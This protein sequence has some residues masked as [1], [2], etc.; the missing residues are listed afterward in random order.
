MAGAQ[1]L[2]L[3]IPVVPDEL[4]RAPVMLDIAREAKVGHV[5]Y[6]SMKQAD[7]FADVAHAASK[8]A[9]EAAIRKY[10]FPATIL[11]PN[12]FLQNDE[13]LK[14]SVLDEGVYPTPI[15]NIGVPDS[16]G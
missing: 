15:G 16:S 5:V 14:T 2:F 1:A 13:S 3:L 6:F 7:T 9:S 11:R 12:C 10:G 4:A 8:F